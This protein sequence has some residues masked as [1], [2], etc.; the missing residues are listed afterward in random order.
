MKAQGTPILASIRRRLKDI[1]ILRRVLLNAE[2]CARAEGGTEPGSEHLIMAA[3]ALPDG[4]ARRA[5]QR[6]GAD[7]VR[8]A[9]SVTQQYADA[10]ARMG[11]DAGAHLI[12]SPELSSRS[13]AEGVF[14]SKPSAQALIRRVARDRPFGSPKPLLGVDILLAAL[15]SDVGTVAR[16][17]AVMGIEPGRLAD[18]CRQEAGA[19]GGAA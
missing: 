17:L 18:A 2:A 1:D 3:L 9:P 5:F 15:A 7:P 14:K 4:T 12:A 8:F 6:I 13:P 19:Y 16:A 10:L 11:L